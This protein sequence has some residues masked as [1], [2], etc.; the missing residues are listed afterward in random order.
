MKSKYF[1]FAALLCLAAAAPLT[2]CGGEDDTDPTGAKIVTIWVHKN[3]QDDEGKVYKQI[4][5]QFN[6]EGHTLKNGQTVKMSISFYGST[7]ETKIDGSVLTNKL[8]DII[9]VDSSDVTAKANA[10]IIVPFDDYI[11]G[12]EKNS[13]VDSVIEQGTIDDELY[14]LSPMEA[15]GGVYYNKTMLRTAGYTDADFPTYD[16]P[17]SWNDIHE[18]QEKLKEAGQPYQIDLKA[19]FGDDGYMYLYSP[20]VYSAGGS[21]GTEDHVTE[22]LTSDEAIN[23]IRQ[24]EQFYSDN[25][26]SGSDSPW[27]YNG[28][29]DKAFSQGVVPFEVYGPWDARTIKKGNS[30]VKGNYGIMPYPV[31]EDGNGNK[32]DIIA[33]PC[34]SF[35]FGITKSSKN[36]EASSL[37][38]KYLC[39]ASSSEMLYNAIGTYPTNVE[40]LSSLEDLQSGPE[41]DLADYLKANTYTRPHMV[42]YPQLKD[43]YGEVLKYIKLKVNDSDYDLKK[44]ITEQ[45]T[46]VDN[47][48]A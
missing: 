4:Q 36:L 8:P 18:A 47:A 3:E 23:G 20:L 9:A 37:V 5:T 10:G 1:S 46:K 16:N 42:K 26:I 35:G 22:A 25:G 30:A 44:Q 13:F 11:T 34:G 21:F 17:W 28:T 48:R 29:N 27:V 39:G 19:G 43:A 7:L 32:G 40:L 6:N 41:K 33:S 31:Y 38:L 2:S 14:F 45:M 12:E 24:L 15:P